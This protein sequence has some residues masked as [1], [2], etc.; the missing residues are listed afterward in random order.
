MN[1]HVPQSIQTSVEL[2]ELAAVPKQIISPREHKPII[3]PV[4]DTL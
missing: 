2:Q 4:Q 3:T 1:M